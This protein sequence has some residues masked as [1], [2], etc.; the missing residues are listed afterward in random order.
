[1]QALLSLVAV[2]LIL[3]SIYAM[4]SVQVDEMGRMF[5][6]LPHIYSGLSPSPSLFNSADIYLRKPP[7]GRPA[8][9][10]IAEI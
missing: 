10:G 1:M 9:N 7:A 8:G 2:S 6:F 3:F 4:C 5:G